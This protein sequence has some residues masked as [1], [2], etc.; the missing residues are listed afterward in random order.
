MTNFFVKGFMRR[1]PISVIAPTVLVALDRSLTM[2]VFVSHAL[3]L[4]FSSDAASYFACIKCKSKTCFT[5]GVPFHSGFT[6]KQYKDSQADRQFSED[7]SKN[8]LT[9]N[10]KLCSCG[11][12]VQKKDG[13]DHMT[14]LCGAEWCYICGASYRDIKRIGNGA[15]RRTC[16]HY[17]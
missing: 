8:W 14:C 15:H 12:W 2:E 13:C 11:K 3:R 17:R 16:L 9:A 6:C 4:T 10:A 7:R 1:I 5:C